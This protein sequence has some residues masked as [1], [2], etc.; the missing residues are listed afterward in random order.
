MK[1]LFWKLYYK[2]NSP[3]TKAEVVLSYCRIYGVNYDSLSISAFTSNNF[4]EEV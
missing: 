4:K 1:K 3:K 2:F